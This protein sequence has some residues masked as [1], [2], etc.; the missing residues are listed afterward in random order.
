MTEPCRALRGLLEAVVREYRRILGRNLA[1]IYLHGSAAF[2][3][4]LWQTSDIDLLVAVHAPPSSCQKEG[5]VRTLLAQGTAAPP[6]GFEMSVVLVRYCR[7]FVWPV[8]YELHFSNM[9]RASFE[10]DLSAACAR[11]HGT[12][13]DLAAHFAVTR[14]A[15]VTL[16]GESPRTMFCAIP[17]GAYKAAILYDA[18]TAVQDAGPKPVQVVLNLCRALAFWQQGL[19]LS[20]QQG[21]QWA[22]AHLA[23]QWHPV[24]RAALQSYTQGVPFCAPSGQARAFASWAL[25]GLPPP[26]SI[27]E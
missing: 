8:P 17:P 11:I 10:K 27:D 12:D 24:V 9:H 26:R 23:V 14:A 6:A 7:Q 4:F 15:G 21:G 20:K 5:L 25:Q 13:K 22:L 2:G 16:W 18:A 19:V 3:C 1:G